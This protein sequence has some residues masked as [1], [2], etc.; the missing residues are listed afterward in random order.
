MEAEIEQAELQLA[1]NKLA[2]GQPRPS[3]SHQTE[4]ETFF[5]NE[6][7]WGMLSNTSLYGG[8]L[9][10]G[11]DYHS[12]AIGIGQNMLWLGALNRAHVERLLHAG[13]QRLIVGIRVT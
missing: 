10:S 7:S 4:N 13:I 2:A 8:L 11:D 5:S 9:L 1:Q 6:V 12:A 3:M